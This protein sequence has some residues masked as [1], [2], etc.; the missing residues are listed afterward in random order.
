MVSRFF[1]SEGDKPLPPRGGSSNPDRRKTTYSKTVG[2]FE[3]EIISYAK[4]KTPGALL[5]K[6][7]HEGDE[8]GNKYFRSESA[9]TASSFYSSLSEN[10]S[11]DYRS[12]GTQGLLDRLS[13]AITSETE[14][15]RGV[16]E[17]KPSYSEFD[18]LKRVWERRKKRRN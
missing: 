2:P 16:T 7:Y 15:I 14:L 12:Y 11:S 17:E 13:G 1:L 9:G 18:A 3:L 8:V 6:L 5:I 4:V 10:L